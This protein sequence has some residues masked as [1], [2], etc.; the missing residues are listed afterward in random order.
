MYRWLQRLLAGAPAHAHAHYPGDT[1]DETGLADEAPAGYPAQHGARGRP[2]PF[3]LADL[4]ERAY[5]DWLFNCPGDGALEMS[6]AE[7]EALAAVEAIAGSS[8]S[9]ASLVR[10]LPGLIPQILQSLR[11]DNFSGAQ[12][13]RTISTDVVLVA[14]VIRLANCALKGSGKQVSS[15]EHAV[16]MIGQEGLRHLITSVAFRPIIDMKSGHYTRTLAPR[17]WER[18]ERCA[19]AN[20]VLAED[21][22]VPPFDAFLAG[23]VQDVGMIV[24]LRAIDRTLQGEHPLGSEMF[25]LQLARAARTLT[26]RIGAEW[27]FPEP[28]MQAIAEQGAM[29]AG[30]TLSPLGRMV[31][32]SGHLG[33]VRMLADADALRYGE[34]LDLSRLP[35]QA[36]RCYEA[37]A[38]TPR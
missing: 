19:N 30:A 28:V 10:R 38:A 34:L 37:L 18:S 15:V 35:Q 6:A 26:C 4:G 27:H 17:I 1:M 8:Q 12:L 13:S 11:S 20:R 25:C 23:L 3:D 2:V 33:R 29:A 36:A 5:N 14:A 7:A 21:E 32:L 9:C 22:L 16:L 24:A 31:A